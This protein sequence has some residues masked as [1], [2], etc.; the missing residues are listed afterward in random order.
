ML[1]GAMA[2]A[3]HPTGSSCKARGC[4]SGD[5]RLCLARLAVA[6]GG[7]LGEALRQA[8]DGDT[9]RGN[10][11]TTSRGVRP[12]TS[13]FTDC[14]AL[15]PVIAAKS[16]VARG[17]SLGEA[18]RNVGDTTRCDLPTTS[19]G[20][21]AAP[22][23]HLDCETRGLPTLSRGVLAPADVLLDRE[24]PELV[25]AAVRWAALPVSKKALSK[26]NTE[27]SQCRCATESGVVQRLVL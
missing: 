17:S 6:R 25:T 9:T 14:A 23:V 21:L 3:A 10:R 20:V 5:W 4:N 19:R 12:P 13:V 15:E 7:S 8:G 18:L 11:P 16:A 24:A 1:D 27:R 22:G 2:S 26:L